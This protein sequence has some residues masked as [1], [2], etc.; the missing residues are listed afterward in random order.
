MNNG[1]GSKFYF[2][3]EDLQELLDQGAT[4]IVINA[5]T[6]EAGTY[7]AISAEGFDAAAASRGT[8]PGCPWPC[9]GSGTTI[10]KQSLEQA[11]ETLGGSSS[12]K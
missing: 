5:E 6:G 10:T 4:H 3:V 9:G 8:K 12:Y 2:K 7:S 11:R 1:N